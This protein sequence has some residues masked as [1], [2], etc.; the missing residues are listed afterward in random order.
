MIKSGGGNLSAGAI[1]ELV[2]RVRILHQSADVVDYALS[3]L[4]LLTQG[5]PPGTGTAQ[6]RSVV[7]EHDEERFCSM[8]RRLGSC[9]IRGNF[10]DGELAERSVVKN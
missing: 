2:A 1:A 5:D 7:G 4:G 6:L 9:S 3:R 10:V 8:E